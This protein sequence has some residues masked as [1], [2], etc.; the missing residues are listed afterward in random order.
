LQAVSTD[1][2]K[3]ECSED[4]VYNDFTLNKDGAARLLAKLL[5]AT[6]DTI[7]LT[8]DKSECGIV[9]CGSKLTR[10][11]LVRECQLKFDSSTTTSLW[12]SRTV[13][14]MLA[15]FSSGIR[16]IRIAEDMMD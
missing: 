5:E 6:P 8:I 2:T 16:H 13:A 3:L 1:V 12:D 14:M 7:K 15:H 9:L 10:P 4:A 11:S